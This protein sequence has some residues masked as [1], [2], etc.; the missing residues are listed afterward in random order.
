LSDWWRDI[1]LGILLGAALLLAFKDATFHWEVFKIL[2]FGELVCLSIPLALALLSPRRLAT[3]FVALSILLFRFI[4]L[5][6]VFHAIRSMFLSLGWLGLWALAGY[7]VNRCYAGEEIRIPEGL[8]FFELLFV[9][10]GIGGGFYL[11]YLL[12]HSLGVN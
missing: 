10:I 2:A 4:F 9:P 12:R 7:G 11:L 1:V 8:T 5:A 6:F 3:V